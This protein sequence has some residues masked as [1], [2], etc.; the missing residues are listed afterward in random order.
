MT[1]SGQEPEEQ[2]EALQQDADR[3]GE[4]IEETRRDWEAKKADPAV[5]GA[6]GDPL[7]A[8]SGSQPET[9]YP[10]KGDASGDD[11]GEVPGGDI[12]PQDPANE[13]L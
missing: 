10:A 9:A 8:A 7:A 5:P 3:L 6:G 4:D 11:D 13:D 12:D 1:Q 2:V